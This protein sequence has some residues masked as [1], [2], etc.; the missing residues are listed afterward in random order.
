[1]RTMSAKDAAGVAHGY[2]VEWT[3]AVTAEIR[4]EGEAMRSKAKPRIE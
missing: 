4:A 2:E 1:M 3:D